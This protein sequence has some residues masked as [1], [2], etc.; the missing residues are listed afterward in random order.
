[1][2]KDKRTKF[3]H[4]TTGDQLLLTRGGWRHNT[5]IGE[6]VSITPTGRMRVCCPHLRGILEYDHR[7]HGYGATDGYIIGHVDDCPDR[8]NTHKIHEAANKLCGLGHR[9]EGRCNWIN[10][11]NTQGEP[12]HTLEQ[13]QT[14]IDRANELLD[15][16]I[17]PKG[18]GDQ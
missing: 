8:V 6:V 18:E 1:M 5:F 4:I 14:A 15:A 2:T 9:I 10:T 12:K 7:G 16:L 17:I 11:I 13:L 3:K